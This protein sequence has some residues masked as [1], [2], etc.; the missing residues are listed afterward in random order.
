MEQLKSKFSKG[1]FLKYTNKPNSFVIFEGVDLMPT[2]QYTKKLSVVVHYDPSKYCENENGMGW[3]SRPV[4][5][6]AK[7]GKQCEKTVDTYDEDYFWS[8]CTDEEKEAA[9][10][11]LAEYGYKWDEE[12]LS[13]IDIETGEIVHRIIVPKLEYNGDVIKPICSEYKELLSDYALS[14]NTY[15]S[16]QAYYNQ[17]ENWD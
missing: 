7:N 17:E 2:Y 12:S 16:R 9:I 4:L 5:E 15:T 3:S 11:K 13:L 8:I 6:V 1:D 14:K 10:Q